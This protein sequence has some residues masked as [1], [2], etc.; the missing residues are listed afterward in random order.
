MSANY[1]CHGGIVVIKFEFQLYNHVH[2]QMNAFG[3]G[4]NFL[5]PP[6]MG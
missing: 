3:K 1:L 2:F 6:T 5:M 4:T